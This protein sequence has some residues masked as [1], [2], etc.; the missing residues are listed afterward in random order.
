M[1]KDLAELA[2]LLIRLT[3]FK[4]L[5]MLFSFY[6]GP[7]SCQHFINDTLFNFLHFFIPV[8]LDNIL[9]YSKML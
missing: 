9:I 1:S 3:I 2:T 8:Y 6:N 7:A 5:V 4:Y